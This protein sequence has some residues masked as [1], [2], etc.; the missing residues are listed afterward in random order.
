MKIK[1]FCILLILIF[2]VFYFISKLMIEPTTVDV[3]NSISPSISILTSVHLLIGSI[4]SFLSFCVICILI[5]KKSE[6]N[7]L[8]K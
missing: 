6:R 8:N 7:C 4:I 1:K 3:T 5:Y 2:V